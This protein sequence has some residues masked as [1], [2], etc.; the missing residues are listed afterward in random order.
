M[1]TVKQLIFR[2]RR[3]KI[4]DTGTRVLYQNDEEEI[5]AT[6]LTVLIDYE[7]EVWY[8]MDLCNN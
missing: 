1:N 5:R 8:R 4:M 7:Q 3:C 6:A 2:P